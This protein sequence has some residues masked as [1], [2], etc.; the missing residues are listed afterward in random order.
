MHPV[1]L[2]ARAIPGGPLPAC[3]F[4][5]R[6]C[7]LRRPAGLPPRHWDQEGRVMKTVLRW[8]GLTLGVV[9]LALG[10][11]VGYVAARPLPRYDP[12]P[13]ALKV[14]VTPE[15]VARGKRHVELLCAAC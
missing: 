6:P 5:S 4:A 10:A 14:E 7:M 11:F 8:L 2:V 1:I 12:R 15:R 3:A 9:V 13:I